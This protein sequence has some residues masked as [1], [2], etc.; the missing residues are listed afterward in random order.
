LRVNR[1]VASVPECLKDKMFWMLG[2]TRVLR[3]LQC[4]IVGQVF[5]IL[6]IEKQKQHFLNQLCYLF[7][8]GGRRT[9]TRGGRRMMRGKFRGL[10]IGRRYGRRKFNSNKSKFSQKAFGTRFGFL[11]GPTRDVVKPLSSKRSNF[12]LGDERSKRSVFMEQFKLYRSVEE[13]K[14]RLS[15]ANLLSRVSKKKSTV[16]ILGLKVKQFRQVRRNK[17]SEL[18]LFRE[19]ARARMSR[20]GKFRKFFK[21]PKKLK[22]RKLFS[23]LQGG[24]CHLQKEGGKRFNLLVINAKLGFNPQFKISIVSKDVNLFTWFELVKL[25]KKNKKVFAVLNFFKDAGVCK[26]L[27]AQGLELLPEPK[28]EFKTM[29][30]KMKGPNV[31]FEESR[32]ISFFV[33]Q[34][35]KFLVVYPFVRQAFIYENCNLWQTFLLLVS[36]KFKRLLVTNDVVASVQSAL[37]SKQARL[38]YVQQ[39]D[40]LRTSAIYYKDKFSLIRFNQRSPRVFEY[41]LSKVK[42]K[43]WIS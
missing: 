37:V 20:K 40:L 36:I 7:G 42:K 23:V 2:K 18:E 41:F 17:V 35:L 10:L 30:Q 12:L 3:M 22:E 27:L 21:H 25:R 4:Q 9:Q 1:V 24:L 11:N 33:C 16:G 14:L 28:S 34:V 5:V 19:V 29:L 43:I 38:E 31:W 26:G 32:E 8:R 15:R 13:G 39:K 6:S